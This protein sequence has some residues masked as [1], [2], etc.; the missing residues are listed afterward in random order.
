M[1]QIQ[2]ELDF[3]EGI[4]RFPFAKQQEPRLLWHIAADIL[5]VC[6]LLTEMGSAIAGSFGRTVACGKGCG[7]C[8]RQMVPLSPP[9]AAIIADVVDQLPVR[10]EERRVGKE[11][12]RLCRSRWSPYH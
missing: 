3:P 7:V 12:E 11:C 2:I 1:D 5:P 4:L 8:C 10:S 9:E 6:D